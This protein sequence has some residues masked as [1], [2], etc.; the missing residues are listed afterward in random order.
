MWHYDLG[1]GAT[2]QVSDEQARRMYAS[3]EIS[4]STWVWREGMAD[5]AAAGDLPFFAGTASTV[6]GT[7]PGP[8]S[9]QGQTVS[10]PSMQSAR[11][12]DGLCILAHVLGLFTG[13]LG[14]LIMLLASNE[15]NVKN[16]ARNAF[17][18]QVSMI[19]YTLV[20]IPLVFVIIGFFTIMAVLVM[21]MVFCILAA[22][23][24]GQGE[25]WK[26]PATIPFLRG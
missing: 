17:N 5:W 9:G 1:N 11:E 3:G 20:S 21:D 10:A 14:P 16:H 25:E 8:P 6:P 15:K 26:Y 13:F 24:A 23:K 22:V 18:W 12:H 2:A 7:P 19:L 4:R